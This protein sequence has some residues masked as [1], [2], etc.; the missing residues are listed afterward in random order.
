VPGNT[1]WPLL[2][3]S[4]THLIGTFD[5]DV[6]KAAVY[7]TTDGGASWIRVSTLPPA[8]NGGILRTSDDLLYFPLFQGQGI[9]KSTDLGKSWTKVT[10]TSF[11]DSTLVELPDGKVVTVGVDH[12]MRSSDQGASWQAIGEPLPFRLAGTPYF[13]GITY[14]VATKTFFLWRADCGSV[15]LPDAIMSAGFDYTLK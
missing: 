11:Y 6:S 9:A 15:V 4:Q 12:L 1:L 10:S 2:I 8:H 14:S 5:A 3:D 13:G 7:R